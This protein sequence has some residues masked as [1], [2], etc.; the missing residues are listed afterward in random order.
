[1]RVGVCA[2]DAERTA[3]DVALVDDLLERI[4]PRNL[5]TNGRRRDQR[6]H[7]GRT[8]SER[9]RLHWSQ[10]RLARPLRDGDLAALTT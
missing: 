5:G 2:V 3:V 9:A 8:R 7:G 4:R 1:M 6:R 10:R